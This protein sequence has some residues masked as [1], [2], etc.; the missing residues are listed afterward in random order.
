[1]RNVILY[2]ASSLDGF[3][4]RKN[5]DINWLEN[6]MYFIEGEDYGYQQMYDAIDTTLMGNKTYQQVLG[7][8]VPFP[9]HDKA[10]YVFSRSQDGK[11]ENV[12]FIKG[13][14]A[15]FVKNL[16]QQEGKDIWLVGG[17]E[18]NSILLCHGLVDKIILTMIPVKLGEGIPLFSGNVQMGNDFK[19][20]K[21]KTYPN[22]F[23]QHIYSKND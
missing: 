17:G 14:I 19:M 5:G 7:F 10:N 21:H 15:N 12:Q 1:M 9:Y 23:V 22:G 11:D 13:D 4:A 2:I 3:I 20:E 18:L 6:P 8:D 16:K